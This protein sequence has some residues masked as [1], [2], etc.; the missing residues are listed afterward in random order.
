M[1]AKEI[2]VGYQHSH[3]GMTDALVHIYRNYGI[4]GLW[5]GVSGAVSRVM[6]GSAAQLSTYSSSKQYITSLQVRN[7]FRSQS[8]IYKDYTQ[9]FRLVRFLL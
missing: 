7:A 8:Q 3:S 4:T 9:C 5:R 1:A 6:V 2:A